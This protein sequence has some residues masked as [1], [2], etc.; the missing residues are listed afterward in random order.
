MTQEQFRDL[1]ASHFHF[2]FTKDQE[3]LVNE[4]FDFFDYSLGKKTF[5]LKGY[6]G[7]GKTSVISAV[8]KSLG[9][10]NLTSMLLAPTGRA[11]KVLGNYSGRKAFT[12]HKLIYTTKFVG[13]R[14]QFIRKKNTFK[15]T[16]FI[17]DEASMIGDASSFG[18]SSLL[19]DLMNYVYE[20]KDCVA[21]FV[22]DTAQLP[23]VHEKLSKALDTSFLSKAFYSL[24]F[25]YELTEVV[26]QAEESGIL[27]NATSLRDELKFGTDIYIE[28]KS[29]E[30]VELVTGEFLQE[31][32][33]D[34]YATVGAESAIVVCR[35]NKRANIYNQQIRARILYRDEELDA[36]DLVM[37]VKNNYAWLPSNSKAGFI[38]NGD[39]LEVLSV[40]RIENLYG[41][42]FATVLVRLLDY[43]DE[44]PFETKVMMD[45]I[46]LETT[47]LPRAKLK[48]LYYA[49]EQEYLED[50]PHKRDRMEKI[51]QD[52]YFN[53]LQ[54]KFAY[55]VTCHKS[56]GGQW[57]VVFIDQGY[58]VKDMIDTEYLRWLYTAFTRA[59]KKLYLI[60]FS[61]LLLN[62]STE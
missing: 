16:V 34:A 17:I 35:S 62:D 2:P 28:A 12:I 13:G 9:K 33:E 4:L 3:N 42:K 46:N 55:A 26:R 54:I 7:T 20:G 48:E 53:A 30:D 51:L 40:R 31:T 19:D 18:K 49:I 5:V 8:I 38:A 23:P 6:A 14:N 56:Q 47:S 29:Y 37:V 61:P 1:V 57:P 58:L 15:R 32:L 11:A 50:W 25:E 22:G 36:G 59:S 27:A 24:V 60:N 44:L 52:P 39:I 10:L 45:T 43:P 41:F 21:I